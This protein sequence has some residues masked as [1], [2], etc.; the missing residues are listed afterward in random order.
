MKTLDWY[1]DFVSPFAYLQ[2]EQFQRLPADVEVRFRPVLLAALLEHWDTRDAAEIPAARRFSL[3]HALW[4]ARR[5]G[6]AL[7]MPPAHPFNPL[8]ALR[9]AI[10]LDSQPAPVQEIFRFIWQEGRNLDDP[11]DWA[12]LAFR[13]DLDQP[14]ALMEDREVRKTLRRNTDQAI[15]LGVFGVPTFAAGVDLFYG[16]EGFDLLL[17]YLHNPLLFEEP[18]MVR[19]SLLPEGKQ[20]KLKLSDYFK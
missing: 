17:D 8:K 3:R 6:I 7:R 16:F 15:G 20:R 12:E 4:L 5:H 11:Q 2:L 9:L 1:F 10:A 18:E 13:F 14:E 19:V